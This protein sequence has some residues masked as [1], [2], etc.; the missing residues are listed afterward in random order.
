MYNSNLIMKKENYYIPQLNQ[1]SPQTNKKYDLENS[2]NDSN[3]IKIPQEEIDEI[4]LSLEFTINNI[5]KEQNKY[6]IIEDIE[7][8]I[9]KL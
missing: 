2:S 6:N 4:I 8:I 5:N 3:E 1:Y 7:N 9:E